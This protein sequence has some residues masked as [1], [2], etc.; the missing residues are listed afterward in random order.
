MDVI[1][2]VEKAIRVVHAVAAEG[3]RSSIAELARA[4]GVAQTT[5]YRIVQTLTAADWIRPRSAGPGYSLSMGLLPLLEPFVHYQ[6]L[7]E[8]VREPLQNLSRQT[9]LALKVSVRR[10][11]EAVTIY[12]V[13]S[14]RPMGVSGRVGA[15]FHLAIGSSGSALLSALSAAEIEQILTGAPAAAWERQTPADVRARVE[16][17]RRDGTCVDPG[18][19]HPTIQTISAPLQDASGTVIAAVT[20]LGMPG[21]FDGR[22]LP[23]TAQALRSVMRRCRKLLRPPM[24]YG[25]SPGSNTSAIDTGP[26]EGNEA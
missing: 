24:A 22:R 11:D 5:C 23:Q 20:V 16:A 19:F 18:S 25:L 15:R 3:G 6:S 21:D 2:S 14:P 7:V 26:S 17:V 10:A 12:R 13:E 4:V 8:T 9:A 1:P